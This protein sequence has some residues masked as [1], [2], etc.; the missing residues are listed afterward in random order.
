[1]SMLDDALVRPMDPVELR[2]L[3]KTAGLSQADMAEALGMN[4]ATISDMERGVAPIERR[5][6]LAARYIAEKVAA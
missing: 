3:R 6:G 5:T 4:R 1:M 2:S